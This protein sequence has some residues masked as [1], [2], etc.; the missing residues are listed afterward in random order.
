VHSQFFVAGCYGRFPI[1]EKRLNS[2]G[3][4]DNFQARIAGSYG[5]RT[6]LV[7][8]PTLNTCNACGKS[9]KNGG[10]QMNAELA[11]DHPEIALDEIA[12]DFD[13]LAMDFEYGAINPPASR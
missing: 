5:K 10:R 1:L 4:A 9:P 11:E 12:K 13:D 7:Q 2:D 6:F 3:C 8:K